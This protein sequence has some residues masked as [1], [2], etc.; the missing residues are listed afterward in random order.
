METRKKGTEGRKCLTGG[1][2]GGG[3]FGGGGGGGGGSGKRGLQR[4]GVVK[5]G[6]VIER[7]P[8]SVSVGQSEQAREEKEKPTL[9]RRLRR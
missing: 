1:G 4:K 5:L 6:S 3:G 7:I 2:G 9:W 8:F